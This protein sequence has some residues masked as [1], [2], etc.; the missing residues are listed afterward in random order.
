MHPTSDWIIFSSQYS[1]LK[2]SYIYSSHH[3]K[4]IIQEPEARERRGTV[5]KEVRSEGTESRNFCPQGVGVHPL[6]SGGR[7][8]HSEPYTLEILWR[9]PH[10][11]AHLALSPSPRTEDSSKFQAS[12]EFPRVRALTAEGPGSIF[13]VRGTKI[14]QV[15]QRGQKNL[16]VPNF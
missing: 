16:K 6:P 5:Y 10:D 15:K 13:L 8:H 9:L 4:D 1:K 7:V 3:Q 2:H 11:C 14:H 12:R